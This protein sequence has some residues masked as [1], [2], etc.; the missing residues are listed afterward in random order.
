MNTQKGNDLALHQKQ[1]PVVTVDP[2]PPY[3]WSAQ[4]LLQVER[5]MAG[6]LLEAQDLPLSLLPNLWGQSCISPIEVGGGE[7]GEHWRLLLADLSEMGFHLFLRPQG[8]AEFAVRD[9]PQRFFQFSLC[10]RFVKPRIFGINDFLGL[11]KDATSGNGN[12]N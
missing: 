5:R 11:N 8:S 1:N 6:I 4:H 9:F 7:E 10:P 2:C 3:P 12:V